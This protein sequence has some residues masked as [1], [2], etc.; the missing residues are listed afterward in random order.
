MPP[1]QGSWKKYPLFLHQE[2][3]ARSATKISSNLSENRML[4]STHRM[5]WNLMFPVLWRPCQVFG[6]YPLGQAHVV[7]RSQA[8]LSKPGSCRK[9]LLSVLSSCMLF[10]SMMFRLWLLAAKQL[11]MPM[12]ANVCQCP[13]IK[14]HKNQKPHHTCHITIYFCFRQKTGGVRPCGL[15]E[16]DPG[17]VCFDHPQLNW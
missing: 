9:F 1:P 13:A 5:F 7:L 14:T 10:G 15:A 16:E 12:Y 8:S 3:P 2:L 17:S 6:R 4:E 11:S